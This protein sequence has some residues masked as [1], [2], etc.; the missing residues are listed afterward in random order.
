MIQSKLLSLKVQSLDDCNI[1]VSSTYDTVKTSLSK[2]QSLEIF[3]Y[4][5]IYKQEQTSVRSCD[6]TSFK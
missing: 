6:E 1:T 5:H 2:H 3:P 4:L